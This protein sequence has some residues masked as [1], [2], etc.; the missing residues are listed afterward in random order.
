[1]VAT[2]EPVPVAA[3][4]PLR[5]LVVDDDPVVAE[6]MVVF[7]GLEGHQVRSAASG[8]AALNLMG[9]YRPQVVLLDIGL[10]GLDGYEV[11]RRIRR[12]PGG[13]AVKLVAVS[14]YGHAE[15]L[16]RSQEAGFDRH[17][18]KPVAAEVLDQMLAEFTWLS[19][20]LP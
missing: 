5:V 11:A 19:P 8:E 1:M 17:L 3:I 20:A 13:D 6:S 4:P 9:E 12:L 14:G 7:L 2:P 18:V 16:G 10:P 15:A